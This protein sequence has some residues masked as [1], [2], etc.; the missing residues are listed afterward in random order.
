MEKGQACSHG[1]R[2]SLPQDFTLGNFGRP[3]GTGLFWL[4]SWSFNCL[5]PGKKPQISSPLRSAPVEMTIL[6]QTVHFSLTCRK[7]S[8]EV[9]LTGLCRVLYKSP[10]IATAAG[11]L[12]GKEGRVLHTLARSGNHQLP[13]HSV[14]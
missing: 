6:L 12:R 11:C 1:N 8:Q 5:G 4:L 9:L 3:S 13:F 10:G 14:R 7:E 2:R